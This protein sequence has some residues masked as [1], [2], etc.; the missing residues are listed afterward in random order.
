MKKFA[1][2]LGASIL[3]KDNTQES[4]ITTRET[5]RS[6]AVIPKN[7]IRQDATVNS[8]ASFMI[9]RFRSSR[10]VT[11]LQKGQYGL[12]NLPEQAYDDQPK[13]CRSHVDNRSHG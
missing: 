12:R 1:N 7:T 2:C 3:L 8:D 9:T 6:V 11:W 5:R 13:T 10:L 4:N